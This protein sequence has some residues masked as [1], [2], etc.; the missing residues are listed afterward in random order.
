MAIAA[1]GAASEI[2]HSS[3]G[4]KT[5][6]W[7]SHLQGRGPWGM[8]FRCGCASQIS[9][10]SKLVPT[11]WK[12]MSSPLFLVG[13]QLPA[14]AEFSQALSGNCR[15]SVDQ[16]CCL[17]LSQAV[18]YHLQK[19]SRS[20]SILLLYKTTTPQAFF[21]MHRSTKLWWWNCNTQKKTGAW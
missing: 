8:A 11:T 2:Q 6:G 4:T 16:Q 17:C 5:C 7:Q 15:Q 13:Q 21:Q 14:P 1:D 20:C 3:C 9:S 12:A 18:R 10:S 19:C